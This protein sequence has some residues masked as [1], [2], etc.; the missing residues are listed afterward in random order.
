MRQLLNFIKTLG[1]LRT[2]LNG[3]ALVCLLAALFTTQD[4]VRMQGWG[5]FPDVLAPV[6]SVILVFV[7][8][9][10]TLMSRVYMSE[11]AE[12]VQHRFRLII[13]VELLVVILLLAVWIPYM[14]RVLS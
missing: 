6:L 7:L 12:E 11:Q 2:L 4:E 9:L 5:L 8:L 3:G 1:E 13:R 10:D 14:V